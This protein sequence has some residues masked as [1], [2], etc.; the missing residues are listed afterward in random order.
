M[1]VSKHTMDGFQKTLLGL[2]IVF[3]AVFLPTLVFIAIGNQV[4]AAITGTMTVAIIFAITHV[5][6]FA[7]GAW[8]TR[9]TMLMGAD[10]ALRAQETN[11]RWDERKTASFTRIMTEGARIG[12]STHPVD[13]APLPMPSQGAL[14]WMPPVAV[15][16]DGEDGWNHE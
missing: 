12:R 14:D 6:A 4:A 9:G 15:L 8:Y 16:Q 1:E 11:D 10:V 5:A 2:G 13:A 3:C 7:G